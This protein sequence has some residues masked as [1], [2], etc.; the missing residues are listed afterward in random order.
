MATRTSQQRWA[1]ALAEWAIPAR[2]LD[3]APQ[4]PWIHPVEVFVADAGVIP[5]SPSHELA[6]A[7]VPPGGSVL[8]VGCGGGRAAMALVP[9]AARV[10]GVDHQR[11]MLDQFARAAAER[12]V[13]HEEILGDWPQSAAQTPTADVV[14]CHHVAYNVPALTDFVL[15]LD[16]QAGSRVVIELPQR[17]PLAS[18]APLWRHFWALERPTGPTA[19]D[20]LAV[21]TQALAPTGAQATLQTWTDDG[22]QR[23]GGLSWAQ[24]VEF[25]RIRLCLTADRDDELAQVMAAQGPPS[26]RQV[27]T[28]WWDVARREKGLSPG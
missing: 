24:Q 17:H 20:A 2:I 1:D 11:G 12:A 8:D 28:I 22:T 14:V 6:R 3:H 15:A 13:D 21:I 27:A 10:I 4:S 19:D 23:L 26:P 9:P 16:A 7:A 5:D 25:M 18:M